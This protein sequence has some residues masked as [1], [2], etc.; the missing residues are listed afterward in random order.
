ML[1][2]VINIS[3]GRDSSRIAAFEV[4]AGHS[5]RDR[6]SDADHHRSVFTLINPPTELVRDVRSLLRTAL[7]ELDLRSH[8]GVHPRR[9]VVDVVPFV[10]LAVESWDAAVNLRDQTALWLAEEMGVSVFLYGPLADGTQRTLPEIRRRAFSDLLPDFGP[11]V[12]S[13]R[14][15]STSVGARPLLLAWNLWLRGVDLATARSLARA[16]RASDLR[17]MGWSVGTT[18]QLSCNLIDVHTARPGEIYDR[19]LELLPQG[20]AIV[21][22][23]LVGLAPRSVLEHEDPDRWEQLGLSSSVT[24]ESRLGS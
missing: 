9:G 3:E 14:S 1:E 8:D 19:V 17:A 10:P 4:A 21:R 23:E 18:T 22:A 2:C 11:S 20:G 15:G 12:P 7:D 6:H 5:L 13:E 16:L 24:I